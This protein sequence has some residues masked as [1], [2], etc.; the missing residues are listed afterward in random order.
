MIFAYD[1]LNEPEMRWD[2]P[3]LRERWNV[4][5]TKTYASADKVAVRLG[6]DEQAGRTRPPAGPAA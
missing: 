1:L 3:T 4:W 5:L 6:R 2:T